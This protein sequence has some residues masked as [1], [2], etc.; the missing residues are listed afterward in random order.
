M[1]P[2][3]TRLKET[4]RSN[5]DRDQ[6]EHPPQSPSSP[7]ILAVSGG[8]DSMALLSLADEFF[9]RNSFWVCHFH[10]QTRTAADEDCL[11]VETYCKKLGVPF[12]SQSRLPPAP[13]PDQRVSEDALRKQRR[14]FMEN[15][16]RQLGARGILTAHHLDDWIETLL[17]RLIRGTGVSGLQ[18]IRS[19][20]GIWVHPLLDVPKQV[21]LD[22]CE[23][24]NI[25]FRTDASNGDPSYTRNRVRSD[26][27]VA[28]KAE[29][30]RKEHGGLE[31]WY[32]RTAALRHELEESNQWL[33]GPITQWIDSHAR[34]TP[35]WTEFSLAPFQALP[36]VTRQRVL[37][38][39]VNRQ[40]GHADRSQITRLEEHLMRGRRVRESLKSFKLE[41]SMGTAFLHFEDERRW[42]PSVHVSSER[43]VFTPSNVE[44]CLKNLPTIHR[45]TCVEPRFFKPG[46]RVAGKKLKTVWNTN[47]VPRP[48][49]KIWPIAAISKSQEIVWMAEFPFNATDQTTYP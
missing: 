16:Q 36:H 1:S 10:H 6:S 2:D 3:F 11:L 42:A 33:D 4:F 12:I 9:P 13:S 8:P 26:L 35:Y 49:R 5:L 44:V 40:K 25:P 20:Q 47:R 34:L 48:H 43:W 7:W 37:R 29:A 38:Q 32:Q 23:A 28:L 45:N 21:L 31:A 18:S 27:F 30:S 39:L 46:D 17:M 24:G 15:V 41:I 19:R 22:Y 14:R